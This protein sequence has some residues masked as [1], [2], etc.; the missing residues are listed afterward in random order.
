MIMI[1]KK[2]SFTFDTI[3]S[4][5]LKPESW[6]GKIFLTF[7]MDWASDDVLS[8]VLNILDERE[9]RATFFVTHQTPLLK[10]MRSNPRI[11]LGIHPNFNH[12]LNGELKE[13]RDFREVI[14][15][16]LTIVPESV[17]VRSHS[18]AQSSVILNTFSEFEQKYDCSHFIPYRSRLRLRPWLHYDLKLIRIPFFWEDSIYLAYDDNTSV[19]SLKRAPGLKVF[20]FHPIHLF[21]NTERLDRFEESKKF[22][23]DFKGLTEL[24]NKKRGTASFFFDLIGRNDDLDRK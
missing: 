9:L 21:L 23:H 2:D 6:Q 10:R 14:Q 19:E 12:L 13:G 3:K 1:Q 11:E 22:I 24:R 7:D 15:R 5:K 4:M 18:L 16:L 17:S 8:S 20:S